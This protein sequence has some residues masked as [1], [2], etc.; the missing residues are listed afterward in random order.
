MVRHL[1]GVLAFAATFGLL[2]HAVRRL[3]LTLLPGWV[4]PPGA[5]VDLVTIAATVVAVTQVLGVVGIYRWWAVVPAFGL[6]A[7]LAE[8]LA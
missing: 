4:G 1:L 2:A 8:G 7:V 3:R 6:V 5:L